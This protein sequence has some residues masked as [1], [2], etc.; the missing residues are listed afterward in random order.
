MYSQCSDVSL[1]SLSRFI[2]ELIVKLEI[3]EASQSFF[4][5]SCIHIE[6]PYKA[7]CWVQE[8]MLS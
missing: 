7:V 1:P 3:A 4:I 5:H 8:I 6:H 2:T